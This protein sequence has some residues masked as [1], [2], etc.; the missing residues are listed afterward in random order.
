MGCVWGGVGCLTRLVMV[1]VVGWCAPRPACVLCAMADGWRAPT[2][3][4]HVAHKGGVM[5]LSV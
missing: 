5:G 1:V 4:P 3:R 2:R